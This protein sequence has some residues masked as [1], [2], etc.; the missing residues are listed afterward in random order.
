[1]CSIFNILSLI[2]LLGTLLTKATS[3]GGSQENSHQKS[4]WNLEPQDLEKSIRF[5][6]LE[7][8]LMAGHV[9]FLQ[10][11]YGNNPLSKGQGGTKGLV[12]KRIGKRKWGAGEK[13]EK[14]RRWCSVHKNFLHH[15]L[16]LSLMFTVLSRVHLQHSS[17]VKNVYTDPCNKIF[18]LLDA[19]LGIQKNSSWFTQRRDSWSA[20]AGPHLWQRLCD[21][22]SESEAAKS[23]SLFPVI[24]YHA[25][26][27][28]FWLYLG[29]P[30]NS[31]SQSH[32]QHS[33][34]NN[35]R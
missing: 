20:M 6:L 12:E 3:L 25:P 22:R 30:R 14:D 21:R 31:F 24:W 7:F 28:T 27:T 29:S 8:F 34:S 9:I 11:K 5:G 17:G 35:W 23:H 13:N 32:H 18:S 16:S 33:S 4:R 15:C 1:M 10:R 2:S 26:F 19:Q